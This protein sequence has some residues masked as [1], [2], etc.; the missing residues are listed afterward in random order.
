MERF[1]EQVGR[2]HG[3]GELRGADNDQK[4]VLMGWVHQTRH[5]GGQLFVL[6]RDRTGMVQLR[7]DRGTG[8][9]DP[10]GDLRTEWVIAVAGL[11][12]HRGDNVNPDMPTG[13]VEVVVE[14]LEVL[15]R[16][17][18][19]PFVIRDDTDASEELKLRYRYLDLRRPAMQE[20]L[21]KRAA[22]CRVSRSYL[23]ELAFVEVETPMLMKSTPEGA[24][25]FLVPS[26]MHRGSFYALPQSPQLFKQILM[27]AGYDRY[28]QLARCFRD[29]DLRADRQP[30]FTQIDLEMSFVSEKDVMEVIEG[31]MARMVRELTGREVPLPMPRLG[32][33]EAMNRYGSDAPDLRFAMPITD[34]QEVFAKSGF[35]VFQQVLAGGGT[36]RAINVP[37]GGGRS[38]KELDQLTA[39]AT[40]LGARGLVWLKVQEGNALTGPVA[41][42]LTPEL[43][44]RLVELLEARAGDLLLVIGGEKGSTLKSLGGLRTHLGPQVFPDRVDRFEFCWVTD[45]PMF[46]KDE[47][48]DRLVAMHHPFTQPRPEDL[49]KLEADPEAVR[50]RAYDIVLN[51]VELG[52]G[53]IRIHS[54]GLQERVFA[55][56]QLG[57]EEART[58]FGFLLEAL[59]FGAPPHGGIALG[60]DRIVMMLTGSSSIRETIAFPKTTSGTCLMAGSPTQVSPGQLE[61]LGLKAR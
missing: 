47:E 23:D 54:T 31:L 59:R 11:A 51:G 2:T 14:K 45:F 46:E 6:L 4:V 42:F 26:R 40:S 13:E 9:F 44:A 7:F 27:V 55:A 50:A 1:V 3:C 15:N 35:G 10:A 49:D 39:H 38:R 57:V 30:E 20:R 43:H 60:L 25:D 5:L 41:K 32:Y 16:A 53:S 8:V 56:M 52:G 61:E 48:E 17:A 36:T 37:R 28:Y 19:V 12:V 21:L 58:K 24:R 22:A 29:E 34:V 33:E 18:T